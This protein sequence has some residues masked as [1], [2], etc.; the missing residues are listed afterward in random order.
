[1]VIKEFLVSLGIKT[2]GAGFRNVLGSLQ[3]L[4]GAAGA[5]AIAFA[6]IKAGQQLAAITVQVAKLGDTID[7]T[8]GQFGIARDEFQELGF[9]AGLGGV[10]AGQFSKSLKELSKRA[11]EAAIGLG[12]SSRGFDSLGIDIRDAQGKL[13]TA[14]QLFEEVADG[15][16]GI[17]DPTARV[18]IASDLFGR[19]GANMINVLK[20]GAGAIREQRKEF[21]SL[22]GVLGTDVVDASV[23]FIDDQLRLDTALQGIKN[24]I[25]KGLLP[26]F[27]SARKAL[28]E[29]TKANG[30]AIRSQLLP[31]MRRLGR[32]VGNLATAFARASAFIVKSIGPM[33]AAFIALL[34]VVGLLV[35]AFGIWPIVIAVV[36]GLI[37][38][39][40]DDL[41]EMGKGGR[42]VI[43]SL[44]TQW[45]A[46]I[47]SLREPVSGD[48]P[49]FVTVAKDAVAAW[50]AVNAAVDAALKSLNEAMFQVE[51]F[52]RRVGPLGNIIGGGGTITRNLPRAFRGSAAAGGVA[53]AGARTTSTVVNQTNN[54][55]INAPSGE[56]GAIGGA[57]RRN[58]RTSDRNLRRTAQQLSLEPAQ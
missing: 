25:A 56:A 46:F 58:A 5:L 24:T 22:G 26:A 51:S 9:V 23:Q 17:E 10:S 1:M 33:R 20:N 34:V 37:A 27:N 12:E 11:G 35:A 28:I 40:I 6:G 31:F 29:W 44:I 50:D 8:A 15:I 43:G 4:R 42:S 53:S 2:D 14:P 45:D 13:K 52:S 49:W 47:E 30:P 41:E 16:K 39:V 19:S 18:R 54:T 3:D 48:D 38:A 55:T 32:F 7:K 21:R 36:I 57:V